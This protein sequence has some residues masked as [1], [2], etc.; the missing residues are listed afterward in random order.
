[1]PKRLNL[2]GQD[3]G[4]LVAIRFDDATYGSIYTRWICKC[5]RC[6]QEQSISTSYLRQG[7]SGT[8]C[9][10][11]KSHPLSFILRMSKGHAKDRGIEFNITLTDLFNLWEKQNG[12]CALSGEKLLLAK[13]IF[14][15]INGKQILI[16]SPKDRNTVSLDRI[17]SNSA[18]TVDNIQ[19]VHKTINTMKWQLSEKE[20][21]NR[22]L[23][24][25]RYA[26]EKETK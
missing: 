8:N 20:F 9:A 25:V 17:D 14:K 4:D 11:C 7:V 15:V 16:E 12:I 19:F 1:M 13:P 3:F 10:L 24:I 22:C 26:E 2:T 23:Q 6:N 18:Y 21:I 5:K